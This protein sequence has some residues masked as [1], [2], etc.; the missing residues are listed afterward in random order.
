MNQMLSLIFSFVFIGIGLVAVFIMLNLQGNPKDRPSA[1]KLRILHRIF[2]YL[3]LLIFISNLIFMTKRL[4]GISVELSPRVT[5]HIALALLLIPV[6]LVKISISRF[7]KKLYSYL[8]PLG[9]MIFFVSFLMIAI[10]AGY[11]LISTAEIPEESGQQKTQPGVEN[12]V[13][14]KI[15]NQ[16]C[17]I[18]HNLDRINQAVKNELEWTTTIE[19]MIRYSRNPQH[20]S[21]TEQATLIEHLITKNQS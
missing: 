16:K 12:T 11:Y 3:F 9:L 10:T 1:K 19:K 20:L 17:T 7:F 8:I 4:L 15:L 6:F 18:C 5:L 21:K 14:E 2:G 13:V